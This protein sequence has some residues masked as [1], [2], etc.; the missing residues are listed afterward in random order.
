[1]S[2]VR[3]ERLVDA[4]RDDWLP[5]WLGYLEFY[6]TDLSAEQTALTFARIT[7]PDDVV[8]GAIARDDEGRA[9]GFVH[10]LTHASTWS[11]GPYCYLEDLFVSPE[12]RGTGAGRSLIAHVTTWARAAACAK[13][14]WLTQS[15][16]ATAR[17]LYDAVA[18][19][20][21]FVH[22]EIDLA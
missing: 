14:Y 10:W 22:Y 1:M 15:H 18:T 5:L 12:A 3:I 9:V 21:G 8:H 19:D 20:T 4:D 6:E 13:V 11:E 16:N 17:A 2:G 7:D